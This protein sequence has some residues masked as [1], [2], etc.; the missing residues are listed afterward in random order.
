MSSKDF[1]LQV[2]TANCAQYESVEKEYVKPVNRKERERKDAT[3]SEIRKLEQFCTY[4]F[5]KCHTAY[6]DGCDLESKDHLKETCYRNPLKDTKAVDLSLLHG[7]FG[8]RDGSLSDI[9][10][11]LKSLPPLSVFLRL[12]ITLRKPYLSR[13]DEPLYPIDNPVKKDK[14]FKVPMVPGSTW[15]GNLRWMAIKLL[16]D[17]WESDHDPRKL[18]EGR[19]QLTLLFG[20][21]KGEEP[22]RLANLAAY[23]DQ[24]DRDAARIYRSGLRQS[25]PEE[26]APIIHH[27]GCLH[28]FPT[29]FDKLGLEVINPHDRATRA[30]KQPIFFESVPQNA[31]GN[32]GLLYLPL[33]SLG[34]SDEDVRNA[35]KEDMDL[36]C[37]AV[38]EM[39]LT[40]GFSAKKKAG[41]GVVYDELH[42]PGIITVS[43]LARPT[44]G[45]VGK[46]SQLR[47]RM[48]EAIAAPRHQATEERR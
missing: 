28:F 48:S 43:G 45:A 26:R 4:P 24:L 36:V 42:S 34:K 7:I 25:F 44:N 3:T 22:S 46:V 12:P 31:R 41:F 40:Y 9:R 29:F 21:E 32:F 10:V 13:D 35:V 27:A 16:V 47:D 19:L 38:E 2:T 23:L 20:D 14:V 39:L 37:E 11:D 6:F 30:G 17:R 5:S 1:A 15:K 8:T 18:G 33:S